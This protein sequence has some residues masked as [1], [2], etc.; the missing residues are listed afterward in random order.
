M[1]A[2][3][4]H[5]TA[6]RSQLSTVTGQYTLYNMLSCYNHVQ[7]DAENN[8][9]SQYQNIKL[10]VN[11]CIMSFRKLILCDV[12]FSLATTLYIITKTMGVQ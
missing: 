5:L 3:N 4:D 6:N 9:F 2:A 10:K 7:G 12:K 11:V 8:I 1:A